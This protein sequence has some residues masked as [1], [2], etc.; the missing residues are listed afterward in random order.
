M[1]ELRM[2]MLLT[3]LG[4]P[5]IFLVKGDLLFAVF[6]ILGGILVSSFSVTIV[7]AQKL[8]PQNLGMASGLM[9][10]FAIGAGGV[11]VTLLGVVADYAGVDI[12]LKS[13]GILPVAGLALGMILR[14]SP[15]QGAQA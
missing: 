1:F 15:G 8:L 2:S 6:F 5:L 12:A 14:Y 3:A 4:F 10:G 7:M 9:T 13:I 11:G